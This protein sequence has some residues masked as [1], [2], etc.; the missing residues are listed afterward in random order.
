MAEH[1]HPPAR[2][3]LD[4]GGEGHRAFPG[5]RAS[6]SRCGSRSETGAPLNPLL[7]LP[8][9]LGAALDHFAMAAYDADGVADFYIRVLGFRLVRRQE[10]KGVV[11]DHRGDARFITLE[12]PTEPV[13]LVI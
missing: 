11:D 6:V 1:R 13:Q 10:A 8:R 9:S 2:G 4:G 3:L 7:D 12:L 5:R